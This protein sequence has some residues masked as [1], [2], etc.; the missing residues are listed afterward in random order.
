L[1]LLTVFAWRRLLSVPAQLRR[2]PYVAFSLAFVLLFFFVFSVI[3]NFG[4]LARERTMMLPFAFVLLSVAV[5]S[6]V[7]KPSTAAARPARR[8]LR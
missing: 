8:A 5:V 2:Q 6:S 3:S 7:F 1:L 4:I